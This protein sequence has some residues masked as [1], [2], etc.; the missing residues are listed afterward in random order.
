MSTS[1]HKSECK[2]GSSFDQIE[3]AGNCKLKSCGDTVLH[4]EDGSGRGVGYNRFPASNGIVVVP[5]SSLGVHVS[6]G[7][8]GGRTGSTI[9]EDIQCC[10]A[11]WPPGRIL[12][13]QSRCNCH[14]YLDYVISRTCGSVI[15]GS[16]AATVWITRPNSK[17]V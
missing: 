10:T 5:S 15:P 8:S 11:F 2:I 17:S 6:A 13:L 3:V 12:D 7:A 1:G 4:L 9:P 16:A 14:I